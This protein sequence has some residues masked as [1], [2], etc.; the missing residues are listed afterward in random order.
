MA[1]LKYN[2]FT[3]GTYDTAKIFL[4][5]DALTGELTK[6]NLPNVNQSGVMLLNVGFSGTSAPVA[7]ILYNSSPITAVAPAYEY[8][9]GYSLNLTDFPSGATFWVNPLFNYLGVNNV[10]VQYYE[11]DS[12][13][14]L[15][16]THSNA[17]GAATDCNGVILI[18]LTVFE[19]IP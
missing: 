13:F 7:Q 10:S 12:G 2:E 19:K 16:E 3:P 17:T 18:E 8:T 6:V 14:F 4:Q 5:A 9:G 1:D 11:N 15:I